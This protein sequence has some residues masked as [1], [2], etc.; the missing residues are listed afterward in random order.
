MHVL[1]YFYNFKSF[2]FVQEGELLACAQSATLNQK[3]L[4][5]FS[6]WFKIHCHSTV[7][8]GLWGAFF[9][10]TSIDIQWNGVCGFFYPLGKLPDVLGHLKFLLDSFGP[11]MKYHFTGRVG[12]M[13]L[14][15][16][17]STVAVVCPGI[18][19]R[20]LFGHHYPSHSRML[21]TPNGLLAVFLRIPC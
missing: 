1:S 21:A 2:F 11:E 7:S 3:F 8:K 6:N 14:A 20:M 13:H 15:P 12:R 19:L 16:L 10:E 17:R 4:N 5:R 9:A 18:F